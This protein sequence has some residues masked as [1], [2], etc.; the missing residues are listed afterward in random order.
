M[1]QGNID[2]YKLVEIKG[3]GTFGTVWLAEDTWIGKKKSLPPSSPSPSFW[4]LSTTPTSF[5]Y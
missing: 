5:K 3:S 4:H 1:L 2:K